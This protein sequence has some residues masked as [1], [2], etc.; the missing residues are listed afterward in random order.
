MANKLKQVDWANIAKNLHPKELQKF[1]R[2]KS[3]CDATSRVVSTLPD[4][5]PKINWA[6][7]KKHASDPKIV[8]E[9]EK[10]Y[11][12]LKIKAPKANQ[13]KL[14]ELFEAKKQHEDRFVKFTEHAKSYI[15][16]AEEV[17]Q[18][19][20]NMIPVPEMTMEDLT[21]TF[22][23]WSVTKDNPAIDIPFGRTPGLSRA[24]AAAYEQPD[25]VPWATKQ[26]W[27]DWEKKKHKYVD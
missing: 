8:A 17:Q 24:E 19:F 12:N 1:N 14:D 15:E 25:P 9:L 3:Q 22:P 2:F 7:Y 13:K 16:S 27:I 4:S 23:E 11:S 6:E 26:A 20:K 18:K 10:N 5:L 21:L